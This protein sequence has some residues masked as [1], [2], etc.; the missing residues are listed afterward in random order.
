[1]FYPTMFMV[2]VETG[3][4]LHEAMKA[5]GRTVEM[6]L[7]PSAGH[8]FDCNAYGLRFDELATHDAHRRMFEFLRTHLSK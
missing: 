6:K 8:C 3:Q 7:Y 2:S 4:R 1:M 5:A